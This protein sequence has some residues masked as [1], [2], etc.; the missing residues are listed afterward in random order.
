[1]LAFTAA[2]ASW[3]ARFQMFAHVERYRLAPTFGT[4]I[5]PS[6]FGAVDEQFKAV[7]GGAGEHGFGDRAIRWQLN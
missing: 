3:F 4:G 6:R 1:L 7:V 2:M 5:A